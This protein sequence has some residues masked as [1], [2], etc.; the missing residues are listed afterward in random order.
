MRITNIKIR[1]VEGYPRLKA[2]AS[3]ILD[4]QLAINDIKVIQTRP[5]VLKRPDGN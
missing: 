3:I 5:G 1:L 4:R 2:Y